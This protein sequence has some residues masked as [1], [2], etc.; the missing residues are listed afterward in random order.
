LVIA[1]LLS[2]VIWLFLRSNLKND[3]APILKNSPIFAALN[4]A[5]LGELSGLAI[6]RSFVPSEAIFWEGDASDWFYIVVEGKVK[7]SKLTSSGKEII[8]SFF[9]AGEMFGEAAVF[10]N[11]P[12]PASAQAVSATRLLGIRK[13]DFVRLLLKN[14]ATSFSIIGILS[15]RLREAQSRLRDLAGERVEQRL[16]RLLLR[17][18]NRLGATLP[19]TRQELSDMAGTTTETTIRVL[20]QWKERKII[21]SVRGKLTIADELKLKLLAEGPPRI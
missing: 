13:A 21:S 8:L 1:W 9:A 19:F 6:E 20:S 16:A 12:Y 5:E 18:S 4:E 7:V 3:P 14:P 10:E 2:L 11:M 17:L 15:G